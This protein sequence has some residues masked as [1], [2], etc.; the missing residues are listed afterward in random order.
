MTDKTVVQDGMRIDWDVEITMDDG[1]VLRADVFRPVEDGRYP[2]L[3]SY[4]P[5][6][7]GLLFEEGYPRQW[8]L[9][10]QEH[11]DVAEGSTNKYQTWE[12]VDPEK[13]VPYGYVCVR[14][15]SR[16]AGRSPGHLS[17][18][19]PRETRDFYECIEW[20]GV[21]T[22]SNGK[23]GLIGIS[24]YAMN[25]WQ[26]AALQPPHLAAICPWEGSADWYRDATHHGG[27]LST[28]WATWLPQILTVQHGVGERGSMN[29]NN[30]EYVAGPETLPEDELA[31]NRTNLEMDILSHP[32]ATDA[33]YKERQIDWSKVT[34]P[35][36]SAG[37]WGGI[38]LHLRGNVEGYKNAASKEKWLEIHGL[39]HWTHFYTDYGRNLQKRFFDYYLKGEANNWNE[40]SPVILNVRGV[41]GF[42][43]REESQWPLAGTEWTKIYLN[44][45]TQKLAN[46][47]V[48]E[49]CAV[50]YDPFGDGVTFLTDPF[51]QQTELTGPMA[52]KLF[53]SSTTTDADL[54]LTVRLFDPQGNE[55]LYSGAMDPR[56]PISQGWLRASH[57]K[58]DKAK[59]TPYQPYHP[60]DEIQPLTPH[61]IYELDVEIWPTSIVIPAG[62]RLGLTVGGSD[63]KNTDE[64]TRFH[65]KFMTGSGA[66]WHD[67]ERDRPKEVFGGTVS[68]HADAG[69]QPYLLVP[70]I[71]EE[72]QS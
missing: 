28:F 60:H 13:W 10:V 22:W 56:T 16:G 21:Q 2:V 70:V 68:L 15:D 42:A 41:D 26:V 30:G 35:I 46:E 5:Y 40:Q 65:T 54:F 33:Y 27:I 53:V 4:G 34:V 64:G 23:V 18:F 48:Q 17:P 57:R 31:K 38:G 20:A 36:L 9:M 43:L 6:A 58:L 32:V 29:R 52:A 47:I 67:D 8:N 19:S 49:E 25:Q 39:E 3:L 59:S 69:R 14:V 55:V 7:K 24:Y 62:Y 1:L 37:N 11:P 51:T 63:Y 66:Y 71:P 50:E 12:A 44:P 72:T 61:E 45:A